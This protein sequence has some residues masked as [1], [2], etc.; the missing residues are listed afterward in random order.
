MSI[1]RNID[2]AIWQSIRDAYLL[3]ASLRDA[4]ERYGVNYETVKRRATRER[5]P[6]PRDVGPVIP[7]AHVIPPTVVAGE[8]LARRGELHRERVAALVE[9]ALAAAL[10]PALES[11]SDIATAVKLGNQAFG[12]DSPS[13]MISINF[14]ATSSSEA[15]SFIDLSTNFPPATT[16]DP[17]PIGGAPLHLPE[18]PAP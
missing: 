4:S 7:P 13:S 17:P 5:W 8:S 6:K 2:P 14:P 9:Q 16:M 1:P 10:P 18:V 15:A 11:W 12:I 3:G